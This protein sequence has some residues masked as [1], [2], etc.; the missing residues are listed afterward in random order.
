[1]PEGHTQ[2]S[3]VVSCQAPNGL[4][5]APSEHGQS[6]DP[7]YL[8]AIPPEWNDSSPHVAE[9]TRGPES[10]ELPSETLKWSCAPGEHTQNSEVSSDQALKSL[11]AAP[12]KHGQFSY[13]K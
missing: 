5:T 13:P 4:S 3:E 2:N 1:M 6:S 12:S 9:F 7:M 8:S 11:C 10:P